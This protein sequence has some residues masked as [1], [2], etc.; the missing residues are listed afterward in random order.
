M[1]HIIHQ[2]S[3]IRGMKIGKEKVCLLQ[4]A[5]DTILFLDGSEKSL[6]SALDLLFQFSKIS[7]LKPNISKTK[8]I[9]IGS[10]TNSADTLNNYS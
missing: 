3:N 10:K 2:N 6:K 8:A 5:D 9:W 7:G 4:Y 1:G